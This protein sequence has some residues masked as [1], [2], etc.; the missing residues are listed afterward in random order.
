MTPLEII[1]CAHKA[2][3]ATVTEF[4]DATGISRARLGEWL[5]RAK[6]GAK[7]RRTVYASPSFDD[8][9]A[10]VEASIRLAEVNLAA[11]VGLRQEVTVF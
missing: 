2:S 11:A 4:A 10:V 1:R 8:I 9:A 7:P 5:S 3:G 6:V